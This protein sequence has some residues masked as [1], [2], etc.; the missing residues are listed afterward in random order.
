M[1]QTNDLAE[2]KRA[3]WDGVEIP[4]LV[5][6]DEITLTE[7][8]IEVPSFNRIT[9]IPNGVKKIPAI[10]M[11]YK[12]ERGTNTLAFF[13]A[14]FHD[15]QEKDLV[16]QRVDRSGGQFAERLCP[17]CECHE[18]TEPGY[19]AA[20]PGIRQHNNK[21]TSLGVYSISNALK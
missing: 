9:E 14:F 12:V 4:G 15:K 1:P 19:D 3:F 20:S 17:F 18:I 11:K 5:S 16:I 21:N 7:A 10:T 2:K 6:V 8:T 13:E